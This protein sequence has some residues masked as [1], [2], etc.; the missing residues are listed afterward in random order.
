VSGV[1]TLQQAYRLYKS[2]SQAGTVAA[3]VLVTLVAGP[4]LYRVWSERRGR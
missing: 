1:K 2:D 4:V 3:G